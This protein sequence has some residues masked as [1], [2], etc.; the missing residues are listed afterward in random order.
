MANLDN[1]SYF[2]RNGAIA[3]KKVNDSE[4]GIFMSLMSEFT[5]IYKA[6]MTAV[7]NC[8]PKGK[9]MLLDDIAFGIKPTFRVRLFW[10]IVCR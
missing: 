3:S 7:E 1:I 5:Y 8:F 9:L 4:N 2:I 6:G 10:E